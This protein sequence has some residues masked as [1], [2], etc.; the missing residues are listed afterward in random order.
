M[1]AKHTNALIDAK[2][3]KLKKS[4]A[5]S[6]KE[7]VTITSL[8]TSEPRPTPFSKMSRQ[9]YSEG[10]DNRTFLSSDIETTDS[11]SSLQK[12]RRLKVKGTFL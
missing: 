1:L 11:T 8:L 2:C 6:H 5:S 10:A 4:T 9:H 7:R 3:R 12:Y